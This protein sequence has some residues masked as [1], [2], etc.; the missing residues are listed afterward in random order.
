MNKEK[1]G[2]ITITLVVIVGVVSV[3]MLDPISQNLQYHSFIDQRNIAGVPNFWNMISNLPFLLVGIMGLHS[4]LA[5]QNAKIINEVKNLYTVLFA[6]ISLVA[7]G[8]AYYHLWPSN[9]TLVWDRLPMTIAF[10]ALFSVIISEHISVRLGKVVF[11]PLLLIGLF[12]VIYWYITETKGE[13]DLRLYL[14]IQFLPMLVMPLIL[15]LFKSKFTNSHGYWLLLCAYI[16][17]KI[18]E[19]YDEEIY[20]MVSFSGHSFKHAIAALGVFFLLKS[21]K[22]RKFKILEC[23][24]NSRIAWSPYW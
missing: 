20:N 8:S 1:M 14:L 4:I 3:L 22:N 17:A 2:K 15:L 6:G 16:L 11:W 23:I 19:H 21:Y 7:F 13:G 10:M 5:S 12:S 9:E 24:V 18:F